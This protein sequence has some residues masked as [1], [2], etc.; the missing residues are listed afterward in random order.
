MRLLQRL[1]AI[2]CFGLIAL[3]ATAGPANPVEGVE[4][5]RL[6]RAQPTDAGNK[7]EVLE[8]FWYGC[9]H[10]F[11]FEPQLAEWAKKRGDLI[12]FKRIPV[13]FRESFGPQQKLYYAL[14]AMG[15]V[16][17]VHRAVFD[18]I[19]VGHVRL[20]KED[21]IFDFVEKQGVDRK[22]FIEV[23]NSFSVQSKVGRVPQLQQAY[24]LESVP[25]IAVGGRFI[26]SPAMVG[27]SLRGQSE[28][29]MHAATL[30]VIDTLILKAK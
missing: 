20:D 7:I 3:S 11:A 16:D 15:K 2:A 27:A 17:A 10:C 13:V 25:T 6:S 22:K 12:T 26:T 8:F 9:P 5:Q 21:S 30:Q 18:A 23:F 4:Y 19:H 24:N 29:A 28:Q 14:E 1:F